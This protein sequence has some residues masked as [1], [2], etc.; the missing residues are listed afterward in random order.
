MPK[1]LLS[2]SLCRPGPR[3][4]SYR[5]TE[6]YPPQ[7]GRMFYF[8]PSA[9]FGGF[10]DA[11]KYV[12]RTTIGRAAAPGKNRFEGFNSS[13]GARDLHPVNPGFPRVAAIVR[14]TTKKNS[15]PRAIP[16]EGMPIII[17]SLIIDDERDYER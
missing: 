8:L 2:C 12:R 1:V 17:L 13:R 11:K 14:E 10:V 3:P 6:E 4:R 15:L 16:G 9:L 5:I 7:S